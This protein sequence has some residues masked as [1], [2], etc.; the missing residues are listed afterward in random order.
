MTQ[1]KLSGCQFATCCYCLLNTD[2][3]KLTFARGGHPYPVLVRQ[4]GSIQQ[5]QIRG[6]LLGIFE[7]AEY[8]QESVQLEKGDKL[9][10]YSDGVEPLIGKVDTNGGFI[11]T[12]DFHSVKS[13]PVK[14]AVD[15]LNAIIAKTI[16]A[17]AETDDITIV[18]L[19]IL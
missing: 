15:A 1:Q 14:E 19:E 18:G 9:F 10:L 5:L 8:L 16:F 2:T 11:F 13:L 3:L 7:Q 4:D 6:P 17:A 12:E